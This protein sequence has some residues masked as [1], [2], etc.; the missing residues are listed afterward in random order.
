MHLLLAKKLKT[1]LIVDRDMGA[2][3]RARAHSI[4]IMRIEV[5]PVAKTRRANIKQFHVSNAY[6]K[7]CLMHAHPCKKE[8]TVSTVCCGEFTCMEKLVIFGHQKS[9]KKKQQNKLK[10]PI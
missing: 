4:Q 10:H 6:S 3:H 9:E 7:S 2:R 1:F 8:K 5:I